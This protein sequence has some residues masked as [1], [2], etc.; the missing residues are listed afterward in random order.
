ME[1]PSSFAVP[2]FTLPTC[3]LCNVWQL[4]N[5]AG[6]RAGLQKT[7]QPTQS[8]GSGLHHTCGAQSAP[9]GL[10]QTTLRSLAPRGRNLS[11]KR[12]RGIRS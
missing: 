5:A 2:R 12:P 8:I 10:A 11:A 7:R 4:I 1:L 6:K 3:S 9:P